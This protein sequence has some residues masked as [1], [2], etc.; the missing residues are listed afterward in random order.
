VNRLLPEIISSIAR[1]VQDG[2]ISEHTRQII[3]LTH[4]CR[5]W[6]KIIISTPGHW[7]SISTRSSRKLARLSLER[8]ESA[9][10]DINLG[11]SVIREDNWAFDLLRPK[12]QNIRSLDI[13]LWRVEDLAAA[14]PNFP[15]S[16]PNLRSLR[17]LQ[18]PG[19]DW[20]R[21]VDP[22]G[23]FASCLRCLDLMNIPLY[24]SFLNLRTL[25]TLFLRDYKFH[26]HLDTLLDFLEENRSLQY[27]SLGISFMEPSLCS[28]RR[29]SP[30]RNQLQH[31]WIHCDHVIEVQA[32][33]SNIALQK[34]AHLKIIHC[35][36]GLNE[37]LAGISTAHL[38]NLPSP[39][40]IE[41][42][43]NPRHIRLFG[44]NGRFSF[45]S[46][47]CTA[48]DLFIEFPLL[49]LTN[50]REFRLIHTSS[51]APPLSPMTHHLSFFPSLETLAVECQISTPHLPTSLSNSSSPP[52][53]TT[54]AF[55]N[56]D[57]SK[58][59]MKE[60][61]QFASDRK[62]TT[63]ARLHRVV[64]VD[65]GGKFPSA[66]SID[67]L[68]KHVPIIDIRWGKKLPTDLT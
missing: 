28:S 5:Y 32:L 54:L 39:T 31:L 26:L 12:S 38:S 57:L 13:S 37:I 49:P 1:Y 2:D 64:I 61:T 14:F 15:Q 11:V 62:N 16:T 53:L 58:C 66:A 50:V 6:R 68:E 60:L 33:I 9:H 40:S 27:A 65:S 21:F 30:I 22:F 7:T 17:M 63:S 19:P 45:D 4:V 41:Y 3:P 43:I 36:A 56:C 52:S 23:P 8:A 59:F 42:E 29:Q 48:V 47:F 18:G 51:N 10:L 35:T 25:T 44:P 34:G 46:V 24:P 20:D 67:A 55:L